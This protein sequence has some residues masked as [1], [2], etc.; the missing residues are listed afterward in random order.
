MGHCALRRRRT[1][2]RPAAC[3]RG[4]NALSDIPPAHG[5]ARQRTDTP[6]CAAARALALGMLLC[7]CALTHTRRP[8]GPTTYATVTVPGVALAP[9]RDHTS[10]PSVP[11]PARGLTVRRHTRRYVRHHEVQSQ[12]LRPN[13]KVSPVGSASPLAARPGVAPSLSRSLALSLSRSLALS[14]SLSRARVDLTPMHVPPRL[15]L[16]P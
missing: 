15:A 10:V 12:I 14:L 9:L 16:R 7:A 1:G 13:V 2:T 4:V 8:L 6:P 5:R 11:N 3:G